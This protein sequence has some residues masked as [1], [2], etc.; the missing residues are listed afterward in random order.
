MDR[1]AEFIKIR[2]TTR[3]RAR[4]AWPEFH[5]S[6][7]IQIIL[8]PDVPRDRLQ[9]WPRNERRYDGKKVSELPSLDG[10][11]HGQLRRTAP[12]WSVAMRNKDLATGVSARHRACSK[13]ARIRL[14][15]RSSS[16]KCGG[17]RRLVGI[18][19]RYVRGGR[20][21]SLI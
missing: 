4:A 2:F 13:R 8:G 3:R 6:L 19:N 20:V 18:I 16:R 21:K 15:D 14:G 10:R 9:A 12:A 17:R 11:G 1:A 5:G 7:P